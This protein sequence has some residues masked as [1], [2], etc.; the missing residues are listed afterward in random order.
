MPEAPIKSQPVRPG[1]FRSKP[2]TT[3]QTPPVPPKPCGCNA[4]TVVVHHVHSQDKDVLASL[5]PASMAKPAP[6]MPAA[7][8][9]VSKSRLYHSGDYRVLVGELHFNAHANSWHLRYLLADEADV[10]GGVVK[11][12][13]F[14]PESFGL[15]PGMT[16]LVQGELA[17]ADSRVVSPDYRVTAFGVLAR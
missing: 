12:A 11:L 8:E 14:E 16:V 4:K 13:G 9:A 2:C 5:P 1:V 15:R 3:C 6:I 7:D 10:H 17:Q